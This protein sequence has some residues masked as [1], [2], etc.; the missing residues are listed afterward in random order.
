MDP[1]FYKQLN[2]F[3]VKI[4]DPTNNNPQ[5][6]LA[7]PPSEQVGESSTSTAPDTNWT[8]YS[9]TVMRGNL[10]AENALRPN[11]PRMN[12]G[13]TSEPGMAREEKEL[14]WMLASNPQ[15][16]MWSMDNMKD[17]ET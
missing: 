2:S 15:S 9:S 6:V 13:W 11:D 16:L 8:V 4:P 14:P 10:E 7:A 5:P 12:I 3:A 17:D 1:D